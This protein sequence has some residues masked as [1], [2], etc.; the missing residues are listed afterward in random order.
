[1]WCSSGF[2]FL[3]RCSVVRGGKGVVFG[4]RNGELEIVVVVVIGDGDV[5]ISDGVWRSEL[6]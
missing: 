4:E 2:F 3:W 5:T 6:R 1:M